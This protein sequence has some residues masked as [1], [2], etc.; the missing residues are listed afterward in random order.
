MCLQIATGQRRQRQA[1]DHRSRRGRLVDQDGDLIVPSRL[2]CI[3]QGKVHC[4]TIDPVIPA[5]PYAD[6]RVER[7]SR[8]LL[9]D[10]WVIQTHS[11]QKI[12]HMEMVA[13][14]IDFQVVGGIPVAVEFK[15]LG[16][17]NAVRSNILTASC[18]PPGSRRT[19]EGRGVK[20]NCYGVIGVGQGS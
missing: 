9:M 2:S 11:G 5:S 19:S 4:I 20:S 13:R 14:P 6:H 12:Q 10:R 16:D 3:D 17:S 1:Q 18:E 8:R 7:S 15:T